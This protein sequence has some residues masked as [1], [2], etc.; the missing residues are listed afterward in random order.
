MNFIVVLTASNDCVPIS[1]K[2]EFLIYEDL[3]GN[4]ITMEFFEVMR[5]ILFILG[6]EDSCLNRWWIS[7][8]HFEGQIRCISESGFPLIKIMYSFK[9]ETI[10]ICA[11]VSNQ[12][13]LT[14]M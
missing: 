8:D 4:A 13:D 6:W 5:K 7:F 3:C 12:E 11:H 14:T 10:S 2:Y 1:L 9:C